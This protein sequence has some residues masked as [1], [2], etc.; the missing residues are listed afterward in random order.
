MVALIIIALVT[1]VSLI[2]ISYLPFGVEIDGFDK[3]LISAVVLGVVNFLVGWLIPPIPI[4]LGLAWL[5]INTLVFGL[6]AWAVTGF[7]LRW[8]LWSAILGGISLT[9]INSVLF[10]VLGL[11]GISVGK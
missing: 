4:T 9:F 2:I 7:R 3:A 11:V 8:G 6:A 10:H 1:A 5:I